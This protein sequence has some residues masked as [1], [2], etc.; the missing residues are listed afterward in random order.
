MTDLR[1]PGR[2]VY[3]N[4]GQDGLLFDPRSITLD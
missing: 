3:V 4:E 1:Q 2:V